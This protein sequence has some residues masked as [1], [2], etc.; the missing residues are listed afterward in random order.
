MRNEQ[1]TY[2]MSPRQARR[3]L[4]LSAGMLALIA[5]IVLIVLLV[6]DRR[7]LVGKSDTI[8]FDRK[9]ASEPSPLQLKLR[10]AGT[11]ETEYIPSL[12]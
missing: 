10:S 11:S 1:T 8:S 6:P 2:G 7:P 3:Q 4:H 5:A 9:L 12:F